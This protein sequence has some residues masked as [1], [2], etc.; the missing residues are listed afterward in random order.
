MKM[1]DDD[2]SLSNSGGSTES[3][4]DYDLS[5]ESISESAGSECDEDEEEKVG[6]LSAPPRNHGRKS[7]NV[8]A[9]V[10]FVELVTISLQ[11]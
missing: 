7:K 10:R 1:E 8:A 4:P 2:E 6:P 9:L 5:P 11:Q 3:E